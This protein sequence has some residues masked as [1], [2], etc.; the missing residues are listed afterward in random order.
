MRKCEN[1]GKKK[2]DAKKRI[3]P[4]KEDVDSEKVYRVLCD[5]CTREIANDI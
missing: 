3:D 1:C 5:D 4:Y 2:P